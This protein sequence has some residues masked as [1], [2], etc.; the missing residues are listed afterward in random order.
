MNQNYIRP[1]DKSLIL[2]GWAV[3]NDQNAKLQILVDGNVVNP[4]ITRISRTDVDN[5]V[6]V[7]YGGTQET[8][9]AGV[10]AVIDISN[11]SAGKHT[12]K[13]KEFSRYSELLSESETA[14]NISNRQYLRKSEYRKTNSKS[15][16]YKT[17]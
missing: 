11:F 7:Q 1:D 15:K 17:R 3:A 14:F 8:P 12:V 2:E 9:K 16:I 13:I 10:K 5:T 6:S 4:N